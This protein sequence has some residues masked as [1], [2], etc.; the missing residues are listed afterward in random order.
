MGTSLA[1]GTGFLAVASM[2][3]WLPSLGKKRRRRRE[4]SAEEYE[5]RQRKRMEEFYYKHLLKVPEVN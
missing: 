3:L 5:E 1:T 2:P 4:A